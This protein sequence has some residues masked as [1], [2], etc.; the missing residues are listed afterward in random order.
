MASSAFVFAFCVDAVLSCV[1]LSFTIVWDLA[2][3]QRLLGF[4]C[5]W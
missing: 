5:D 2:L 4:V 3:N 1:F